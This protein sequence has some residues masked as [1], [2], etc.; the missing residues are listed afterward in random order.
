MS[1]RHAGKGTGL[2]TNADSTVTQA[3]RDEA[4]KNA[5]NNDFV[6]T[7][8]KNTGT[9][10]S[11]T[12]PK[13]VSKWSELMP[14]YD[15][16]ADHGDGAELRPVVPIAIEVNDQ[17]GFDYILTPYDYEMVKQGKVCSKCLLWQVETFTERCMWRNC[18]DKQI[19]GCGGYRNLEMA[20][21][22]K[23]SFKGKK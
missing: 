6:E 5:R 13:V 15:Q 9:K 17:G 18:Q 3:Q 14:T 4:D 1:R 2:I 16:I 19:K 8:V 11:K 20:L 21:N 23:N 10:G 22:Y 12:K 7:R